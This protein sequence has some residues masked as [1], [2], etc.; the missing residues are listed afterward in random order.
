MGSIAAF[1]VHK[2]ISSALCWNGHAK[3]RFCYATVSRCYIWQRCSSD[4]NAV[5]SMLC[6]TKTMNQAHTNTNQI[7]RKNFHY[8]NN[9]LQK[10]LTEEEHHMPEVNTTHTHSYL[11][12][13]PSVSPSQL[14]HSQIS[15]TP[16]W[17]SYIAIYKLPWSFLHPSLIK[18]SRW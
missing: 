11:W 13:S 18:R 9:R 3:A 10:T 15:T 6:Q 12:F 14:T 2:N 8:S 7:E 17:L 1:G 4:A 5:S 16:K